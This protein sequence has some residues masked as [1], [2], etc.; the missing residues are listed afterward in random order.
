MALARF[1]ACALRPVLLLRSRPASGRS[2]ERGSHRADADSLPAR[3]RACPSAAGIRAVR[4]LASPRCSVF[5]CGFRTRAGCSYEFRCA[6]GREQLGASVSHAASYLSVSLEQVRKTT[7]VRRHRVKEVV[8]KV[9]LTPTLQRHQQPA[10]RRAASS[11]RRHPAPGRP[12]DVPRRRPPWACLRPIG[13]TVARQIPV[14]KVTRSNRVSVTE[15]SAASPRRY[16][17]RHAIDAQ[18]RWAASARAAVAA[19]ACTTTAFHVTTTPTRHSEPI[20]QNT[21]T[22]GGAPKGSGYVEKDEDSTLDRFRDWPDQYVPDETYE[23]TCVPGTARD[24]APLE[25]L[26]LV[27]TQRENA[28]FFEA[29]STRG[30]RRTTR[31]C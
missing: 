18:Q 21:S 2:P 7:L 9:S 26:S 3:A 17:H 24:N 15:N 31:P 13:A 5:M 4:C 23:G 16:T 10:Q 12:R 1:G 6:W 8:Y 29:P 20:K 11:A 28:R 27:A 30:S 14:L 25:D 19:M 22:H